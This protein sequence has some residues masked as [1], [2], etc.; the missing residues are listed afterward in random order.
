VR[1]HSL[2][3]V[4]VIV[5]T[6][7]RCESLSRTLESIVESVRKPFCSWEV[8]VVD[9]N[10]QDRTREVVEEFGRRHA[11]LFR[12]LFEAEQGLS[13]ARNAGIRNT[14]SPVIVFTDDDVVVDPHWLEN[15]T[16]SLFDGQWV[17]AGGPVIPDWSIK[18]PSWLPRQGRYSL[19]PLAMFDPGLE[20]GP[21]NEA[22]YGA[23][24]AFRRELF[25]RYGEFRVDLG[26][27]GDGMLSNEDTEFG[28]RLLKGGE[29]LRFEPSAIVRHPVPQSRV[30]KQYFR[31]WW[32]N[33]ARSD[34]RMAEAPVDPRL[35]ICGVPIRRFGQLLRWTVQFLV[36]IAPDR[37][38]VCETN[39]C[40]IVGV[41]SE[42]YRQSRL[43]HQQLE[44][45]T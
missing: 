19:A 1:V 29:P 30:Q 21:L 11:G 13:R 16:S 22:P 37:R 12:Y 4:T 45:R 40:T 8:L 35:A 26:R 39:I 32:L 7:N 28:E 44:D 24:M 14:Q 25:A 5:C 6:Y 20:A 41:I 17:G 10:S 38:F 9:N 15:L 33:K 2:I 34:V 42:T 18:P 3:D 31:R 36:T 43:K 23:N 27:C